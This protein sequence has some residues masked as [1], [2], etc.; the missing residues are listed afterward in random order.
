M[1]PATPRFVRKLT[2]AMSAARPLLLFSLL[3]S[4]MATAGNAPQEGT[5]PATVTALSHQ[6]RMKECHRQARGIKGTS[7]CEFLR[8]CLHGDDGNK[9]ASAPSSANEPPRR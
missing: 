7:R 8:R 4:P 6:E 1:S 9:A 2:A 3:F 5:P